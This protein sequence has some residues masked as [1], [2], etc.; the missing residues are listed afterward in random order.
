MKIIAFALALAVC[1][2][3][4]AYSQNANG[5]IIGVV[6][7]PTGAVIPDATITVT[8]TGTAETHATTSGQDGSYQVLNLPVGRYTVKAERPGF[9]NTIT[10]PQ[11]LLINQSLRVDLQLNIGKTAES[12]AVEAETSDVETVNSTISGA[13]TGRPVQELPLNG[14]N[15]LDLALT[16]PGVVETNPDSNASGTYSVGGG[17]SDSVTFLLDGGLNNNL[18]NNGVVLNPNP[19]AIAEFRVLQNNYTAEYGRNSGGIISVVTKSGTNQVHGSLFD[20][21][22]NDAFNANTFFNNQQGLPVPVL[23]RQQF[24]ATLG[25]PISIPKLFSGHDR[26]FFFVGYQGQ[27][28]S[29]SAFAPAVTVY[30]PAELGGDFSHAVSGGPDPNV[31]AFLQSNPYFQ[32]N[33]SLAAQAIIDPTRIDPVAQRYVSNN[34]LPTSP[35]GTLFPQA[36]STDNRDEVTGR[37]DYLPTANRSHLRNSGLEPQSAVTAVHLR[38]ERTGLLHHHAV[39]SN[40]S[41]VLR[42]P[43]RFRRG[44]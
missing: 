18:I 12:I 8:N 31:A 40:T 3:V 32:P 33:P 30:T 23:K 38:G 26:L 43:R 44:C 35:S 16:L 4:S 6:T 37:V 2:A 29:A 42:T 41:A 7:D 25:G 19:D 27:R 13:V 11:E 5:R 20:F 34:L 24:G 15:A 22:R 39:S 14:R 28:Q 10:N 21:V 1:G 36:P 17:R 9:S